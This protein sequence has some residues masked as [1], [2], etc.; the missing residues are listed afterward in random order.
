MGRRV[1]VPAT[2]YPQYKCSEHAGTGWEGLVLS[3]T[4]ATAVVRFLHDRAA[5]GRP[6]Q[7]ERLP[8]DRLQPL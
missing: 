6:Y 1:L 7:D 4:A 2:L 5:D 8:L 3:A